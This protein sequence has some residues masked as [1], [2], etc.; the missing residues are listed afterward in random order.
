MSYT[1]GLRQLGPFAHRQRC[2]A[3]REHLHAYVVGTGGGVDWVYDETPG[4]IY[5]NAG[6]AK[7]RTGR[8]YTNY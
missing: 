7:D 1:E 3:R 2:V 6:G 8:P 4:R 5:A